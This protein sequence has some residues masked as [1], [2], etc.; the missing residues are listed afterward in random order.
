MPNNALFYGC[1]TALVTPFRDG[2]VDLDALK[3]LIDW[4][5][6][7]EI[8]AL[9]VLGTT[10]EPPTLTPRER[11]EI[12]KCAIE[13]VAGRVPIIAGT[14]SND[15]A[16]AIRQSVE[17]RRLGADAVLVV[18]PYYNRASREGLM[19][20]YTAIADSVDCPVVMYNVPSEERV[21]K[22]IITEACA[23]GT[24]APPLVRRPK[25]QVNPEIMNA[26]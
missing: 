8:D 20:H 2:Q 1:G 3:G 16:T 11:A 17:A 25:P 22:V 6:D 23:R 9:I 15:T 18:T 5:I 12:L 13:Q 19:A 4:Q 14:G 7:A 10:G 24:A 21:E 26:I